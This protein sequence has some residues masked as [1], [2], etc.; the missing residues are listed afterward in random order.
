MA[1]WLVKCAIRM[2]ANRKGREAI[3]VCKVVLFI[4]LF[5]EGLVLLA[6]CLVLCSKCQT[7]DCTKYV[8]MY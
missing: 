1:D 6:G 8:Y 2:N 3:N 7:R 5:Y 4:K